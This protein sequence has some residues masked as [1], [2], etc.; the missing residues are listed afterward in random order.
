M[1]IDIQGVNKDVLQFLGLDYVELE[2]EKEQNTNCNDGPRNYEIRAMLEAFSER[3]NS[4][5]YN[6][7]GSE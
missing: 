1:R 4:E 2:N 3:Y 5:L 6:L 7:L